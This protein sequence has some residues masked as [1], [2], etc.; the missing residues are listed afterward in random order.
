MDDPF[1]LYL[2]EALNLVH[3]RFAGAGGWAYEGDDMATPG[4][5]QKLRERPFLL[6]FYHQ[7]RRLW[8]KA[9]PVQLGLGHLVIQPDPPAQQPVLNDLRPVP[10]DPEFWRSINPGIEFPPWRGHPSTRPDPAAPFDRQ[11]DLLFWQ[12][13]ERGQPDRRLAA[14]SVVYTTNPNMLTELLALPVYAKAAGF[15]RAVFVLV[16]PAWGPASPPESD[17]PTIIFY[18]TG[19]RAASVVGPG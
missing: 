15:P 4:P 2:V 6:E 7:L 12:L 17:D 18:D 10:V 1:L 11:P 3:P 14:V 8:D 9:L 5:Q 19:R 13:G 16:G